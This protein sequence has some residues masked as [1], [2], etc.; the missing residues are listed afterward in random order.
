MISLKIRPRQFHGFTLFHWILNLQYFSLCPF[1]DPTNCF[2]QYG[3]RTMPVKERNFCHKLKFTNPYFF[4][5]LMCNK[6]WNILGLRQWVAK[7]R[8]ENQIKSTI[9]SHISRSLWKLHHFSTLN[10]LWSVA[11]SNFLKLLNKLYN[12]LGE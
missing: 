2:F 4:A 3:T 9:C 1:S 8:R 10:R 5:T 6:V 12:E 11:I 7:M